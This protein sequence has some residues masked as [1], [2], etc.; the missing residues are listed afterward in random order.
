MSAFAFVGKLPASK[1][2]LNRL[3]LLQSYS[4]DLRIE[5]DSQC[6][7]VLR[8][9]AALADLAAGREMNAGSAGTVLRFMA[10]RAAREPGTHRI[11]GERRL[12]ARPQQ[13]LL[14]ILKQIGVEAKLS[15]N[16]LQMKGE[17]WRLHGDTLLVPFERSS[18]FATAVLLNAWDLPFDLY[19]SLGGQKVS[20]GYWR[21]SLRM[22]QELGMRIDFWD[23][24]FRVPRGQ[25]INRFSY[26]AEVD[27]SSAFA[28]AAVAAVS[29]AATFLDFPSVGLQPDVGFVAILERMGVPVVQTMSTLKVERTRRL[30]G[31]AVNLKTMPDLFPVLAALCALAEGESDL[32]GAPHLVHKESDRLHQVAEWIRRLGREVE[33]KEDG[34]VI[35]GEPV[36][37]PGPGGLVLNCAGD[38]RLAFAAAVLRAAGF[39]VEIEHPEVVTKSFPEFWSILGW[40]I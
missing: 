31:V 17:G 12:F 3:L 23:G 20:E 33:V 28:L 25:K 2:M 30:T 14:K 16:S 26:S 4:P 15:E 36:A 34:M 10:L 11:V 38:H 40:E 35:R 37:A 6:E 21:M 8:M 5:G 39:A 22:A 32:Y 1:S 7:D 19:V 24:D 27:V 18:Q 13:E 29:G 9:R